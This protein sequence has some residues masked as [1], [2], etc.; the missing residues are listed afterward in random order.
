MAKLKYV[1]NQKS[2]SYEPYRVTWKLRLWRF[3][4]FIITS[5]AFG[6]VAFL[7][8][9][10]FFGSPTERKLKRELENMVFQY[11]QLNDKMEN[12]E[13]LLKDMQQRD[14]NIYR[15]IFEAEPVPSSIRQAGYGGVDRYSGLSGF[16]NSDLIIET[17]KRLDRIASQLYVQS[18]SFDEVYNLARGKSLMLAALPAIQPLRQNDFRA[19]TSHYGVRLDPFY[20][21]YKFHEGVDFSTPV[22]TEVFATGDGVVESV[23]RN[24]F[25]YGNT[26]IINHGFGYQTL[27]AHLSSF[28]VKRGEK[29]KRGQ[30]IG[31]TGNTGKSTSPH[32][33]YEVR[34]GGRPVNPINFF[35][36]DLTPEQ[37]KQILELSS[38]PSQ[39]MD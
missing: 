34:K 11:E 16:K 4:T 18:K 9:I 23:D 20:K 14:D 26:I 35:F 39:S 12:M 6:G 3:F 19:I 37:Y 8:F 27:Y 22:G 13:L 31:K 36:N 1:F 33:H 38:L 30:K 28:S 10:E 21:V 5:G 24:Y 7:F 25:G 29:V 17:H 15:V 2:L 32:L